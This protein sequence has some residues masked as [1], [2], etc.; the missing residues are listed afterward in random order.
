MTPLLLASLLDLSLLT[1]GAGA[2]YGT[3]RWA[4]SKGAVEVGPIARH[5]L[6]GAKA[7]GGVVIPYAGLCWLRSKG[8]K[9]NK[10]ANIALGVV[11]AIEVG[12]TVR[13]AH[14]ALKR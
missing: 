4:L 9:G 2:D 6:L 8:P 1:T 5:S 3:T 7:I 14:N 10:I 11:L 13:N 12:A